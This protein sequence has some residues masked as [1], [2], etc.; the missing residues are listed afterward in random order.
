M[1][2]STERTVSRG[3]PSHGTRATGHCPAVHPPW[4]RALCA[5]GVLFPL[6][7]VSG[8]AVPFAIS[9][10]TTSRARPSL[11]TID[12]RNRIVEANLRLALKV[13]T[14]SRRN[15]YIRALLTAA[16]AISAANLGLIRAAE[17][18]DESAASSFRPM[19]FA[20]SRSSCARK[21]GG[22]R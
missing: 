9:V 21:R 16:E 1:Q 22:R 8:L 13:A 5:G 3:E 14:L 19:R 11:R 18:W 6:F 7:E 15:H 2:E 4:V 10:M 20:G 17:L 12:A